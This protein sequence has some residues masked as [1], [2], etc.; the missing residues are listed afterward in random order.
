MSTERSTEP[1]ESNQTTIDRPTVWIVNLG[2]HDYT[3][4]TNF[5]NPVPLTAGTVNPFNLDRLLVLMA[6]KLALAKESDYILISGP[7]A[8]NA[9]VLALWLQKFPSA[10]ILQW[11]VREKDYVPQH[12][13][14]AALKRLAENPLQIA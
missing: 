9:V 1:I 10:T 14:N 5:G 2:G 11:S 6:P 13:T 12:I 8:L 3:K 7:Q 4:A